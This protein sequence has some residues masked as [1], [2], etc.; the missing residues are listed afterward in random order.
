MSKLQKVIEGLQ[1]LAKYGDGIAG[2]HDLLLAGGGVDV[3]A[4]DA[5]RLK[6]LGWFADEQFDSWAVFIS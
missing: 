5:A 4:E 1:I 3:S 6:D 2:V